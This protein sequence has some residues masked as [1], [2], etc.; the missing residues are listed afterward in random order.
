MLGMLSC[1]LAHHS[2]P[3]SFKPPKIL[4]K[5]EIITSSKSFTYGSSPHN[6]DAPF[7]VRSYRRGLRRENTV[8]FG[9]IN[10]FFTLLCP[11]RL[12]VRWPPNPE[13][14]GLRPSRRSSCLCYG[15]N[16]TLCSHSASQC[17]KCFG[18]SAAI[19]H[20]RITFSLFFKASLS[21][22]PLTCKLSSFSYQWLYTR[23]RFGREAQGNPEMGVVNLWKCFQKHFNNFSNILSNQNRKSLI[24]F[25][26]RKPELNACLIEPLGSWKR[27]KNYTIKLYRRPQK[28][29]KAFA[30]LSVTFNVCFLLVCVIP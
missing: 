8:Y 6:T 12:L 13:V 27:M 28:I 18:Q 9:N 29:M 24:R 14:P 15:K 23:P 20:F 30:L 2:L 10:L 22:H 11:Q 17:R 25:I 1:V 19:I 16:K 26:S 3:D 5:P 7:Q 4:S 21:A